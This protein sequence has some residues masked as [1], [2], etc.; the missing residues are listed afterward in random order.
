MPRVLIC[1]KLEA[2]GLDILKQEK[3]LK[4][5]RLAQCRKRFGLLSF[6]HEEL[7]D[8]IFLK[9]YQGFQLLERRYLEIMFSRF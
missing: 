9:R 1:D 6:F 3:R 4:V 5:Y 8:A 2:A 7:F